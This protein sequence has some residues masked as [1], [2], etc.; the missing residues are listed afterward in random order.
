MAFNFLKFAA[1]ATLIG[2]ASL[3]AQAETSNTEQKIDVFIDQTQLLHLG[4]PMGSIIIGNPDVATVAVH[5]NHTL[6]L[7]GLSFGATNLIVLDSIGRTIHTSQLLVS[8]RSDVGSL[9][10]ARGQDTNTYACHDKCR[11]VKSGM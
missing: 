4:K 6:L 11:P 2:A 5:D 8:E 3:S 7:T 9:T 1:A 10:I